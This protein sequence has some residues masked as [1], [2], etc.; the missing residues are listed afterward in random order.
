MEQVM[1]WLNDWHATHE[2]ELTAHRVRFR[3]TPPSLALEAGSHLVTLDIRPADAP[4]EGPAPE[5]R[6]PDGPAHRV[7]AVFLD[8]DAE[9]TWE[10]EELVASED[11]LRE[12]LDPLLKFMVANAEA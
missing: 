2:G 8:Q 3:G 7:R 4:R 10:E 12:L 9:E 11:D 1:R 6:A 5:G